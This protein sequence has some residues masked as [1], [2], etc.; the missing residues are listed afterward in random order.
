MWLPEKMFCGHVGLNIHMLSPASA[1]LRMDDG[2]SLKAKNNLCRLISNRAM[3]TSF[4]IL[5]IFSKS[6]QTIISICLTFLGLLFIT[7]IIA[8][9]VPIDPVIA[10]VGDRATPDI[11]NKVYKELGLDLP[12]YKQFYNYIA[13]IFSGDLGMSILTGQPVL[14]DI[15]QFFPAT[16]ELSTIAT[17][18]GVLFGVPLGVFAAIRKGRWPDHVIRLFSLVG[19]SVPIFWLGLIAL[20]VFYAKLDLVAGPGRLDIGFE[21]MVEPVTG[22]ILVDSIMAGEW[23]VFFNALSHIIL[24]AFLLGYFSLAYISR[25]TRSFMLEQLNQEYITTARVK[26]MS[27]FKVI[28]IHALGNI[29]VPLIT[30]IALS[31]GYLLEGAVLTETIFA[32]PGLGM[33]ITNSLFSADMSAVLGGTIVVGCV[34]VGIN[35]FSDVLYKYFDRRTR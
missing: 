30:V 29:M 1:I 16:L 25:M 33:Y 28:W 27:E 22:L 4:K 32:W 17:I 5:G 31:Y 6:S 19:Y 23:G 13:K 35:L 7:F 18:I 15:R 26:G 12:I 9:V 8:R 34:F 10:I 24:P 14:D 21:F 11:Y 20:L 3:R 2:K